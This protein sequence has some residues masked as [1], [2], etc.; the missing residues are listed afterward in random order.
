MCGFK[1]CI[2]HKGFA[3]DVEDFE[4]VWPNFEMDYGLQLLMV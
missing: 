4:Q 1:D 3:A 2:S